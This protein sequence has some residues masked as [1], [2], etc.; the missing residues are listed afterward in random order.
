[1]LELTLWR[2]NYHRPILPSG[3]QI[4]YDA[5]LILDLEDNNTWIWMWINYGD[6]L[7]VLHMD[8]Q[9]GQLIN[10]FDFCQPITDVYCDQLT[11]ESAHFL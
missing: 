10:L 8:L 6:A 5:W 1:M 2:V 11:N 4:D 7:Q 9:T 3:G